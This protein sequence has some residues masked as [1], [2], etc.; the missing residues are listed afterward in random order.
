VPNSPRL[1]SLA[2]FERRPLVLVE[3]SVL[4]RHPKPVTLSA[5]TRHGSSDGVCFLCSSSDW[6]ARQLSL[7]CNRI[8]ATQGNNR[9]TSSIADRR[10]LRPSPSETHRSPTW[11]KQSLPSIVAASDNLVR[12]RPSQPSLS[13]TC[14]HN[15]GNTLCSIVTMRR[16]RRLPI[17]L[18]HA[19]TSLSFAGGLQ[20][21]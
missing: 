21:S 17:W 2:A 4:G 10:K 14:L 11:R 8:G 20:L 18:C 3:A 19:L 15:R 6:F 12:R 1:H 5:V 16:V 7:H 9:P 13:G